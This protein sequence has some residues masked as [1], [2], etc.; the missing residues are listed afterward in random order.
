MVTRFV[1]SA[2][3]RTSPRQNGTRFQRFREYARV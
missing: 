1:E 2:F 3:R